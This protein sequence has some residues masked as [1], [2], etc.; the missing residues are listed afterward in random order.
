MASKKPM[1]HTKASEKKESMRMEKKESPG[2][3]RR[4]RKMGVE[5]PMKYKCGGKVGKK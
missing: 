5:K 1:V 4:E 2:F 3:E